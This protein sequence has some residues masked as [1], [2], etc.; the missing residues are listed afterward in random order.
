[1]GKNDFKNF[2]ADAAAQ[3]P[4]SQRCAIHDSTYSPGGSCYYCRTGHKPSDIGR[5]GWL[6]PRARKTDPGTAH[7]GVA[8]IHKSVSENRALILA[9]TF[10]PSGLNYREIADQSGIYPTTASRTITT[11]YRQGD[12]Q[13]IGKDAGGYRYVLGTAS[14]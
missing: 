1:M 5:D 13:R 2:L 6:K 10:P 3:K 8:R 11:M 14:S 9:L 7:E 4:V 12:L